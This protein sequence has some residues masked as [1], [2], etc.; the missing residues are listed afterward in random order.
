[1]SELKGKWSSVSIPRRFCRR[2]KAI[3]GFVADESIA[4]YARQAIQSRLMSDETRYE[5][6]KIQESEIQERLAD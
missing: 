5:E 3:L 4:E 2:I 6:Q 1:M